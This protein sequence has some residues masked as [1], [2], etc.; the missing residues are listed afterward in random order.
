MENNPPDEKAGSVS[1]PLS[2]GL[3]SKAISSASSSSP[4][5]DSQNVQQ[6]SNGNFLELKFFCQNYIF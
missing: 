2:S 4:L 1:Y 3:F 6:S 5:T